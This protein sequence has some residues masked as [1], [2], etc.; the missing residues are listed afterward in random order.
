[1]EIIMA[2][3][4]FRAVVNGFR[5]NKE[6]FDDLFQRDGKRDECFVQAVVRTCR[7]DGTVL[8]TSTPRTPVMG[9]VNGLS[10][11]VQAGSASPLG[12]LASG[13]AYPQEP[14]HVRTLPLTPLRDWPPFAVWEGD[15]EDGKDVVY[16]SPSIWE[17]DDGPSL[18]QRFIEA[19]KSID[20]QFGKKA[21]EIFGGAF[22]PSRWI[23]DSVSLGIQTAAA[24]LEHTGDP[25]DRPIGMHLNPNPGAKYFFPPPVIVLSYESA[26][27]LT[28]TSVKGVP[29]LLELPFDDDSSLGGGSYSLYV[30]VEEVQPALPGQWR[31]VGHANGVVAMTAVQNRLVC[32]TGD[33]GLWMREPAEVD[34]DWLR[35]GH[36]NGLTAMAAL[37]EELWCTT[38]DNGLHVR[39]PVPFEFPWMR[40]GH[41][42]SVVGLA[43]GADGQLYCATASDQLWSRPPERTDINWT[44]VGTANHVTA[45]TAASGDLLASADGR[46]W[47]R[48]VGAAAGAWTELGPTPGVVRGLAVL[49]ARLWA[50]TADHRLWV[51]GL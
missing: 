40:V 3:A 2:T 18:L 7:A 22:P 34:V 31:H 37:G 15:L 14:P 49:G 47:R 6:T 32:A 27:K 44:Q 4:R 21:K 38:T 33:G 9:D 24:Y 13:D 29:G 17:V 30:Q 23:F 51:R 5:V 43:G 11:R 41:A 36:A 25:G 26:K 1:M 35:V 12:G 19:Q 39:P 50:A 42:N 20:D 45:M 8:A 48:P 16:I 28:Q 10:G 46:I